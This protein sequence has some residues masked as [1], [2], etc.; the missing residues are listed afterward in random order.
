MYATLLANPNQVPN[1]SLNQS[2]GPQGHAGPSGIANQ[3][4]NQIPVQNPPINP[5]PCVVTRSRSAAEDSIQEPNP[6]RGRG[7][8]AQVNFISRGRG[9]FQFQKQN[10]ANQAFA[11]PLHQPINPNLN[12]VP[13][14]GEYF[15][16]INS[17]DGGHGCGADLCARL[18]AQS[19]NH[20]FALRYL[21]HGRGQRR[22]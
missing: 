21:G 19:R 15:D 2:Q 20:T 4:P 18:R 22:G 3:V 1:L 6:T 9:Q 10:Q 8:G 17:G 14:S 5:I 13:Y 11:Q 16:W 7:R 12:E